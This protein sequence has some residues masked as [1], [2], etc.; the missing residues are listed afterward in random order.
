MKFRGMKGFRV[1]TGISTMPP[2]SNS[3]SSGSQGPW[4]GTPTVLPLRPSTLRAHK[5]SRVMKGAERLQMGVSLNSLG[6]T[7]ICSRTSVPPRLLVT[8]IW[9]PPG[10]WA[11][12][13]FSRLR[14]QQ[15]RC[16]AAED[17][18]CSWY[19][20]ALPATASQRSK[21]SR[22]V[23]TMRTGWSHPTSTRACRHWATV[24]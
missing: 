5:L 21:S 9:M 16:S 3:I 17:V 14:H 7:T 12:T 2:S 24:P 6:W 18:V 1:A 15:R 11:W 13:N 19:W 8:V 10:C 20:A 22:T 23:A 4:A